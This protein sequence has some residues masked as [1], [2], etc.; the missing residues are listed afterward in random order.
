MIATSW[1]YLHIKCSMFAD[2]GVATVRI[3]SHK[4]KV[5][6]VAD[7]W[8]TNIK[9][10][11][12]DTAELVDGN[13]QHLQL[14]IGHHR[15]YHPDQAVFDKRF[16]IQRHELEGESIYYAPLGNLNYPRKL[17]ITFPGVSSF[18]NVNYRLSALT[19]VQSHIG[20]R[21]LI[22]ALQDK[23]GPFGNYMFKTDGGYPVGAIVTSLIRGLMDR[24]KLDE[25]D[26]IFY[27]NSKGGTVAIDYISRFPR[28]K[29]FT[30][31]PQMDL[32]NYR[33]Q[34][35]LMRLTTGVEARRYYNLTDYLATLKSDNV[36][37]SFAE[38]DF[39]AS[40]GH[41]MR[42]FSGVKVVMLKDMGHS[43]AAMEL[44]KRQ[45]TKIV[46]LVSCASLTDR[47]PIGANIDIHDGTMRFRRLLPAFKTADE[48]KHLYAEVKFQRDCGGEFSVSLN[49]MLK[50]DGVLAYWARP[51]D[52]R[53]H[54][55]DGAYTLKL[56]LYY[57]F[58]EIAYPLRHRLRIENGYGFIESLD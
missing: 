22:I 1:R 16:A 19:S 36:T 56:S 51:F 13:P 46:Q 23:V 18:D 39:D 20:D 34:N 37:Y 28:S 12:G 24:Y 4:V 29:F 43:G 44:V 33:S 38:R 53:T 45:F 50:S 3:G 6:I 9:L 47:N 58:R 5:A 49:K 42:R 55:L 57:R 21:A 25:S 14:V 35:D 41:P 40:R 54:L 31:I 26:V 27:G 15:L 10:E 2:P 7:K 32:F 17:L 52:Y 30:D 48:M 11:D 8:Y